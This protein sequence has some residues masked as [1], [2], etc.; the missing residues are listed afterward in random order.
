MN[1][2]I[3]DATQLLQGSVSNRTRRFSESP[4][5][6]RHANSKKTGND[7]ALDKVSSHDCVRGTGPDD[8][9]CSV[10]VPAN[11]DDTYWV[12]LVQSLIGYFVLMTIW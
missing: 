3:P 11:G 2:R 6:D 7:M 4:R 12:T 1:H 8:T 10:P 5:S 9:V